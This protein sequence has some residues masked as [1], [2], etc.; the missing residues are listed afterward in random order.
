MKILLILI[1]FVVTAS[2]FVSRMTAN[3]SVLSSSGLNKNTYDATTPTISDYGPAPEFVGL[4]KWLNPD[5]HALSIA[6]LKGKVVLV[7]FWTLGCINCI[8]T[9]PYVTKWYDTY[10]DQGL[11]VIGIHTPEF[12]YEH[13]TN[14][15]RAAITQHNIHFPV[16]QDNNFETWK[17]YNNQYW[18]AYYLIDKKG[19]IRYQHFG[20]GEY[21]IV[22]STIQSLL[23]E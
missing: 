21:Q 4:T 14:N 10:K 8:H 9:L 2:I 11:I 1:I 12:A 3:T 17:A 18:P 13:E 22:E 5:D 16:A 7:D 19:V 15:V 20:E 23:K 6:Q